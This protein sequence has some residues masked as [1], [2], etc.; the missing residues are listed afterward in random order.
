M[1]AEQGSGVMEAGIEIKISEISLLRRLAGCRERTAA[2][3]P[4]RAQVQELG[5]RQMSALLELDL[6]E[7]ETVMRR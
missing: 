5:P 7:P 6:L 2:L 1:E 4:P 3:L